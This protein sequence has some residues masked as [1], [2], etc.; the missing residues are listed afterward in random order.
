MLKGCPPDCARTGH[1]VGALFCLLLSAATAMRC[2]RAGRVCQEQAKQSRVELQR[3]VRISLTVCGGRVM[4]VTACCNPD[5][6]VLSAAQPSAQQASLS[7][8][9]K[10]VSLGAHSAR[11]RC[12]SQKSSTQVT[13]RLCI[14]GLTRCAVM[15][16]QKLPGWQA[17]RLSA[18]GQGPKRSP[19]IVT[20]AGR[21]TCASPCTAAPVTPT[22]K[23]AGAQTSRG[24]TKPARASARAP[25]PRQCAP[26]RPTATKCR[27]TMGRCKSCKLHAA[28]EMSLPARGRARRAT[29][30]K[31]LT[32]AG[33][34]AHTRHTPKLKWID[35]PPSHAWSHPDDI[36]RLATTALV[37]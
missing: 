13:F 9:Q 31:N 24:T 4:L 17:R 10:A 28:A 18:T 29:P 19:S 23:T 5:C 7:P 11:E 30:A 6:V 27:P 15:L 37:S 22:S 32:T 14:A 1:F 12:K 16:C 3:R 33:P 25:S 2:T 35:I 36:C 8:P 26:L 20:A 21:T 34:N